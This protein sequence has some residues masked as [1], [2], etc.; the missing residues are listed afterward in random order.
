M[1]DRCVIEILRGFC[2]LHPEDIL[3]SPKQKD[4]RK[5]SKKKVPFA[6]A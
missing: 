5:E 6:F 4:L 2:I 1:L 3:E